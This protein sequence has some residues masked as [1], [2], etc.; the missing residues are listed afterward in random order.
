[1]IFKK[2]HLLSS[3][4]FF[5][6]IFTLVF[7]SLTFA[8]N[9]S[10][11]K[12]KTK[13]DD[14]VKVEKSSQPTKDI[15]KKDN[16]IV[17]LE[18]S[19]GNIKIELFQKEAPISVKN[20]LT[21]AKEKFYDGTIFHRVI[22]N[23]MIQGGGFTSDMK[24]KSTHPPIKNE[25]INKISNSKG[26]LAMARTGVVDSATSQFF[27]NLKNNFF[28]DHKN[29]SQAG[30]GYCVFGQVIEGMNVV[31]QIG[32]VP[33]TTKNRSKDVPATPV[34]IKSV[35]LITKGEK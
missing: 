8:Q 22:S 34:I 16:P 28:L 18:T 33:T 25:A 26:S 14:T 2:I 4:P 6:I 13:N 27:I 7:V 23:F 35:R 5:L 11:D 20:F 32:K 12:D 29:T 9:N 17:L 21:Y 15:E 1:M 10:Q 30:Y 31:E 24:K 19:M 3:L